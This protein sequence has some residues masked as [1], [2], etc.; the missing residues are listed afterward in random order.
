MPTI[1]KMFTHQGVMHV[2]TEELARDRRILTIYTEDGQKLKGVAPTEE[3]RE[4]ASYGVHRENLFLTEEQMQLAS[5]GIESKIKTDTPLP[6]NAVKISTGINEDEQI[7]AFQN[8]TLQGAGGALAVSIVTSIAVPTR[9]ALAGEESIQNFIRETLQAAA[10]AAPGAL[11]FEAQLGM[12]RDEMAMSIRRMADRE[13][14]AY[15]FGDDASIVGTDAWD[16]NDPEDYTREA[17]IQYNDDL[18]DSHKISFHVRFA[19]DGSVDEVYALD[20][21]M[22]YM[23]GQR[24]GQKEYYVWREGGLCDNKPRDLDEARRIC[25]EFLDEGVEAYI[26]DQDQNVIEYPVAPVPAP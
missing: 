20:C 25:Q 14:D 24:G 23:L 11:S 26:A 15:E 17:Y 18:A 6:D 4:R 19:E 22:G 1:I 8:A 21:K 16:T 5:L 9:V 13:F 12:S 10:K 3:A 7:N 2:D